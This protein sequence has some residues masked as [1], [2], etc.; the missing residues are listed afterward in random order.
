[1]TSAY[2]KEKASHADPHGDPDDYSS[3]VE[4]AIQNQMDAMRNTLRPGYHRIMAEACQD[5]DQAFASLNL[6][7]NLQA[8]LTEIVIARIALAFAKDDPNFDSWGFAEVARRG[9]HARRIAR[10]SAAKS[11]HNGNKSYGKS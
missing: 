2:H 8:E 7:L 1:M 5:I 3:P 11:Y 9:D 6:H 10:K 4:K